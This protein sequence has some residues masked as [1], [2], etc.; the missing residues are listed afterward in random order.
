MR[1]AEWIREFHRS[2]SEIAV[3]SLVFFIIFFLFIIIITH[4]PAGLP[5]KESDAE[6]HRFFVPD[7]LLSRDVIRIDPL[8]FNAGLHL[9]CVASR[10]Q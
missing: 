1:N 6:I 8:R 4:F 5:K 2:I 3:C 10:L 7:Y 9:S